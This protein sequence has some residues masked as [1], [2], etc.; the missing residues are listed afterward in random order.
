[1]KKSLVALVVMF[2]ALAGIAFAEDV[3]NVMEFS[4]SNG[5]VTFNHL[6]HVNEVRNDC[7]VC[8]NGTPGQIA[9]FGKDYAHDTCISCH[10]KPGNSVAPT[11]CD[12]CHKQ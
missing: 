9:G 7:D 4:A 11:T 12:G 10:S 8:H 5:T 2:A 6:K 1:M 3:S